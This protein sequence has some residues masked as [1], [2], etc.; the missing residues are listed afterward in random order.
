[1]TIGT[2]LLVIA[3]M[4]LLALSP[5]FRKVVLIALGVL[6]LLV[7][8]FIAYENEQNRLRLQRIKRSEIEITKETL[9][10][11]SYADGYLLS[12][13]IK[14]L[15]KSHSISS[16]DLELKLYDCSAATE[17]LETC[18]LIYSASDS[19]VFVSV[20]PG[21]RRSFEA[22]FYTRNMPSIQGKLVWSTA[23]R[24]IRSD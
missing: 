18:D 9:R 19:Y 5:K 24:A 10:P 2:A 21:Q 22:R 15:S 14:N 8:A 6:I 16:F 1:M 13:E 20:P 17:T 7:I 4:A 12:G 11:N 23:L 3:L